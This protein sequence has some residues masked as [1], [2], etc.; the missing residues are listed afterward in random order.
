MKPNQKHI[1][2][3]TGESKSAVEKSPFMEAL[4]SRGFEVLY[5]VDPIDEYMVQ[6]LKEF[7]EKKL[8]CITKEGLDLELTDEEKKAKEEE[9]ASF[10]GLCKKVKEI[11][12]D[13]V[14]KVVLGDRIVDSPCACHW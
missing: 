9:K 6:Q 12:G 14:E 1:Y 5:L 8:M 10:E 2:Y 4:T 7:E 11:L 13:K 3:I